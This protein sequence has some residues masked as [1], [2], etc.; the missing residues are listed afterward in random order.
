MKNHNLTL[1]VQYEE[2]YM[3]PGK[4]LP[5]LRPKKGKMDVVIPTYT[6]KEIPIA[7]K[8]KTLWEE[9]KYYYMNGKFFAPESVSQYEYEPYTFQQYLYD[10]R[11]DAANIIPYT[12]IY[13]EHT[14][15][16]NGLRPFK[17]DSCQ[18][19]ILSGINNHLAI[20]GIMYKTIGE[21][22]YRLNLF[23]V[24]RNI[25]ICLEN[26]KGS[27]Y[28][29]PQIHFN[30]L[31]R[32]MAIE[33]AKEIALKRGKRNIMSIGYDCNIR[34]YMPELVTRIDRGESEVKHG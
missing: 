29:E 11:H 32:K 26:I 31:E 15:V 24:W 30:A 5:R 12:R 17:Y 9:K 13:D 21:P 4:R 23:R 14:T 16:I 1:D 28:I 7:F 20:N 22:M 6:A 19:W 3:I 25:N 2:T 34:V 8:V 27:N 10:V 18:S 33:K